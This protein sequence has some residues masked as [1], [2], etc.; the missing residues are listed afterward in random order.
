VQQA[1]VVSLR[2]SA[3][4]VGAGLLGRA[5]AGSA[6]V[7]RAETVVA[8][9]AGSAAP[10][11]LLAR[12]GLESTAGPAEAG[13]SLFPTG[14]QR[15][16][17]R[18]VGQVMESYIVAEGPDGLVLV[19]QHA[20][21]ERVLFNQLEGL[22][23]DGQGEV[24]QLLVP[25]LLQLTPAQA[26]LVPDALQ[27]LAACGLEVEEF[28]P[29]TARL[30]AHHVLLPGHRL[31]EISREVLDTLLAESGDA[32]PQRRREKIRATVACH[33]AVRFGQRLSRE[34]MDGLLRQLEVADP[35]ITCPHGR[36]TLLE[37]DEGRLRREFKRP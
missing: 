22:G 26:A 36:P 17:F 6:E 16:P 19:D 5:G 23:R 35:G 2:Q 24:Q 37:I 27:D 11:D 14:V 33:A 31:Q 12:L 29:G 9:G 3:A 32:D 30:V 8:D 18:L 7:E 10:A 25:L 20:A 28:G 4:Y 21:H 15:G 34:E 1:C 13:R